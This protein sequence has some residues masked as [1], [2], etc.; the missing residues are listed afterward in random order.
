MHRRF[1]RAF[2]RW[3]SEEAQRSGQRTLVAGC[4]LTLL[5]V[6][7]FATLLE[8][9]LPGARDTDPASLA[10]ALALIGPGAI[11]W[12]IGARQFL[13]AEVPIEGRDDDPPPDAF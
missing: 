9:G 11:I 5:G 2:R 7:A 6:A 12:G 3:E 4:L 1:A 8:G 13:A 10:W